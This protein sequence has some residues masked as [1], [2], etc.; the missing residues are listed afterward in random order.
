MSGVFKQ[1]KKELADSLI[2]IEDKINT[3]PALAETLP[4]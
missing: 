3:F 4:A 2:K 1:I